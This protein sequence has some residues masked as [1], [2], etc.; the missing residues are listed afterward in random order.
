[1]IKHLPN[2][3][4]RDI[5]GYEGSYRVSNMG[6]VLTLVRNEPAIM[7]G[8][9]NG[10]GYL[11]VQ[12]RK[13]GSRKVFLLH[14]LVMMAFQPIVNPGDF[15]VNHKNFDTTDARLENLEWC[16]KKE[17]VAH[18]L[19]SVVRAPRKPKPVVILDSRF[20]PSRR[21]IGGHHH[22]SQLTDA[23]VLEIRRLCAEKKYGVR[24]AVARQFNLSTATVDQIVSGKTWR[25]LL[26]SE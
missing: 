17:N 23:D 3:E 10:T 16:T 14:R 9:P 21:I 11:Q 22:L 18:Y 20:G 26:P 7:A 12:L 24:T 25:H 13:N 4:W 5:A 19:A 8:N 15:E 6:R 2:E 1:M